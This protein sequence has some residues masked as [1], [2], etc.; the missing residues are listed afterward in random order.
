[1]TGALMLEN[2]LPMDLRSTVDS[3]FVDDDLGA[4]IS[5]TTMPCIGITLQNAFPHLHG[6]VQGRLL[7]WF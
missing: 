5:Q 6:R 4:N 3:Y 7:D 1:M 2:A